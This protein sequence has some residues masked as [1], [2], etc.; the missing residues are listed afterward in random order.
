M[1]YKII[2]CDGDSW[3]A[4][5]ILNPELEKQGEFFINHED[6][7]SYRLPRVWPHKLGKLCDIEIKNNSVAGSSNDGIVRR[8]L[9]SIPK[10][11]RQYKPEELCVIIGWTSPE[12]KDF[13]YKEIFPHQLYSYMT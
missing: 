3:T 9:D 6:N 8:V 5:D 11:L 13:F 2:Y 7:D 12:R 4:G 1:S 10:L